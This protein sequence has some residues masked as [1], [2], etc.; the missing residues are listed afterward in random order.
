MKNIARLMM[1]TNESDATVSTIQSYV[2]LILFDIKFYF[3]SFI[4]LLL[5][6][7]ECKIYSCQMIFPTY[8]GLPIYLENSSL[9][10]G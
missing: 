2:S 5:P 9:K 10:S 1:I 4:F 7:S 6:Q 3:I 8:Q